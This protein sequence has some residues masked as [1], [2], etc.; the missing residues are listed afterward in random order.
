MKHGANIYKYAKFLKIKDSEI[1]DFS[2]NINSYHPKIKIQLDEDVLARYGDNSYAL[3]KKSITKKYSIKKSQIALYNGASSAIFNLIKS[4][5]EK[6]FYLYAPLYGEYETASLASKK[7]IHKIDRFKN[8]YKKPKKNS[9]VVFV[10]PSTPDGKYYNLKR[11]FKIWQTQN[12]SVIL[13]ESFLEFENLKSYRSIINHYKKLYIIQSFSKFYSC[14][15]VR[16]GAIFSAKENIKK[17]QIPLWSLSSFDVEF[18]VK[19]LDDKNFTNKSKKLHL[20]NKKELYKILK[21]SKLFSKIYDSDS[22]FFLVKT[23]YAK[24]IFNQLLKD[25]I[26]VRLCGSFDNLSDDHLRFGVKDKFLHRRLKE[27]INKINI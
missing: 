6:N 18:L 5:K 26:L 9:V 22:N 3:L 21:N 7:V 19:R 27:S 2:S 17:L 10:N 12:C 14:A 24:Q 13:D 15:G 4:F 11:L 16:V 23:N 20:K 25:K 8:I 1:L